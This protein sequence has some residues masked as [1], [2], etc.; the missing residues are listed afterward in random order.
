MFHALP[1]HDV[2]P[3]A[4]VAPAE[5]A[6]EK[7]RLSGKPARHD[8]VVG[9][10]TGLGARFEAESDDFQGF[11]HANLQAMVMAALSHDR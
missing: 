10:K 6:A 2:D 7:A 5:M 11:G 9:D 4:V 3:A 8:P 1:T